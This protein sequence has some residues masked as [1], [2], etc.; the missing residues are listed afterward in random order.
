MSVINKAIEKAIAVRENA[1]HLDN[2][3]SGAFL[4]YV[5]GYEVRSYL[6]EHNEDSGPVYKAYCIVEDRCWEQFKRE[7]GRKEALRVFW[8]YAETHPEYDY[9]MLDPEGGDGFD[10]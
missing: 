2:S 9:G 1:R 7:V 3:E 6:E 5:Y 8:Q 4:G 10:E